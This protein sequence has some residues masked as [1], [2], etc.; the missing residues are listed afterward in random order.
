MPVYQQGYWWNGKVLQALNNI[1]GS[2][3]VYMTGY[4]QVST[5]DK[6]TFLME[7]IQTL[8]LLTSTHW[9]SLKIVVK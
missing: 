5:D 9:F 2:F 8:K 7:A 3:D 4:E 6:I 1:D